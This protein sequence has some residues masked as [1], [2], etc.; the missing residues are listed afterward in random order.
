MVELDFVEVE[1]FVEDGVPVFG[2]F[3]G[4]SEC[5]LECFEVVIGF[6]DFGSLMGVGRKGE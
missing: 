6:C 1:T 5:L 4:G 2:G 3:P